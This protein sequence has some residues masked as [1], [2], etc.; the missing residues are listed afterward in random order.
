MASL[1]NGDIPF[2]I[3]LGATTLLFLYLLKP[4]FFPIFWAIIIAGIFRP[5]YRRINRRLNRSNL[6]TVVVF[7]VIALIILLPAGIVGMLV[8]NESVQIYGR[9]S[10]NAGYLDRNFNH[11]L[12]S[13]AG[14]PFAHLFHIDNTLLIAKTAEIARSITNYIFVNLTA[15]TQNT[16]G[17]LVKFLI[18]LYT[19]FFF[20][21]DGDKFLGMAM[22]I[23]PLGMGR[24]KILYERFIVTARTTLKVTLIIG[25][26][27]GTLGGIVFFIT[28]VEGALI[29]GLLMIL[30]A[31]V[32]VV[33]CSIIWAPAG[34][35]MLLTGHVWEGIL[36]LAVGLFAISTIDN[37][38][39]PLLIGK[40]MEMH[41]LLIFLSTLGGIVLFGFSGFIIGPIITAMLLTIWEIYDEFYRKHHADA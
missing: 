18:M 27:Q 10:P 35:L 33:G 41:P 29:W 32:P 6:S 12:N 38:L 20:I 28:S 8:F 2:F 30:T 37:L 40:D 13:I 39:R 34:L 17:M 15:L 4:F 1:K 5:L 22:R 26:I 31:V 21:R 7:L 3:I 16:L 14:H 36:I 19:L 24:G 11:I 23:L 25:G 9:L